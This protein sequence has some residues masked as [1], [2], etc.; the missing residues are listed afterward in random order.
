MDLGWKH[1]YFRHEP[2]VDT[3]SV[4]SPFSFS[5]GIDTDSGLDT[6][7]VFLVYT[8]SEFD[9]KTDSLPMP[10]NTT[11]R[12]FRASVSP[13]GPQ[14]TLL[15]YFSAEDTL[16]R[17]FTGPAQAPEF[18]FYFN[19]GPDF[20]LPEIVHEPATFL[21]TTEKQLP[22]KA[23]VTD[24]IGIQQVY[25]VFG[26]KGA[27]PDTL[28]LTHTGD[29]F[30]ETVYTIPTSAV[31]DGGLIS[32]ALF[33]V[34]ASLN[35]NLARLPLEG[36]FDV[37][38]EPVFDPVASY[39]T[40]FTGA[41]NDFILGD[42]DIK[43]AD[44]F[45]SE[46]LHSPNPYPSPEENDVYYELI[47]MLRYPIV[48]KDGGLLSFEE[49]VLVEPGEP[50]TAFGD[51]EFWDYVI[52][53]ASID[54]GNNWLPLIDGYDSGSKQTWLNAY[55]SLTVGMNSRAVGT[56]ELLATRE[57]VLTE[58]GHFSAGDTLLIRFRLHS[59]PYANG[60]G[61]AI[62]NLAIQYDPPTSVP[63]IDLPAVDVR[64]YPN[65][66]TDQLT[67]SF[68]GLSGQVSRMQLLLHDITGRLMHV[69]V[70]QNVLPGS[71]ITLQLPDIPKGMYVA[72]VLS[73]EALLLRSKLIKR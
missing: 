62:D 66:F 42:F 38:I 8:F 56:K 36:T 11:D 20:T 31:A 57:I 28:Q 41:K 59:D 45:D 68:T 5:V 54:F 52:V 3:E 46:A 1:L 60:W 14:G 29:H 55:N 50:G 12:L 70:L 10:Y 9:K 2:L 69:A 48:V 4:N 44:N 18:Y 30:F 34:D 25:V 63:A 49:V 6:T 21:L 65:P 53:E 61:W 35:R 72:S 17:Q 27:A 13:S 24:N 37:Q 15:Y 58:N 40:N 33:A 26:R 32:Y 51:D 22:I 39:R 43:K 23:K 47:S 19:Y 73:D 16:N 7:S 67:L 71:E 64:L